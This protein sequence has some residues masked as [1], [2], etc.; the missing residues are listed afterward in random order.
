MI[1]CAC[2]DM[3]L[4]V[5]FVLYCVPLSVFVLLCLCVFECVC[6]VGDVL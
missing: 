5:L 4:C 1:A 6:V 2:F 3:C